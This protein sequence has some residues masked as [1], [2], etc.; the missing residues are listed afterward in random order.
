MMTSIV[1]LSSNRSQVGTN[2]NAIITWLLYN[3]SY[4]TCVHG[5]IVHYTE[6]LFNIL[7]KDLPRFSGTKYANLYSLCSCIINYPVIDYA[8]TAGDR[9]E[10]KIYLVFGYCLPTSL[11]IFHVKTVFS[12][13]SGEVG[14]SGL[15]LQRI[16]TQFSIEGRK[17]VC[18]SKS[19]LRHRNLHVP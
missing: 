1:R 5:I 6:S 18:Q 10:A 14:R 9:N 13:W 4:P 12:H 16:F 15:R 3:I 8:Y 2:Q 19:V 7:T 11:L 17:V